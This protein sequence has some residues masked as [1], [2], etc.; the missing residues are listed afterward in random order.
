MLGCAQLPCVNTSGAVRTQRSHC[1][2]VHARTPATRAAAG[3]MTE[4]APARKAAASDGLLLDAAATTSVVQ[5]YY[6]A[7]LQSTNDLV[8]GACLCASAPSAAVRALLSRCATR[9]LY[10]PFSTVGAHLRHTLLLSPLFQR[11][12]PRR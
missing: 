11:S 4:S 7:T 10:R 9:A 2:L 5:E 12:S 8:T 6:G 3:L 1:S